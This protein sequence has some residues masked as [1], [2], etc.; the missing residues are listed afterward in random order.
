MDP[1]LRGVDIHKNTYLQDEAVDLSPIQ[2]ILHY[3]QDDVGS[4]WLDKKQNHPQPGVLPQANNM[5]F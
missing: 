4:V 2:A 1:R 3:V 5:L